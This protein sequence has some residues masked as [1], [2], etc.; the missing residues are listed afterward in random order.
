MMTVIRINRH[1]F[2]AFALIVCVLGFHAQSFAEDIDNESQYRIGVELDWDLTKRLKLSVE[3]QLRIDDD[4]SVD[5]YQLETGLSY[6]TFG[7]LYWGASYRLIVTSSESLQAESS[8]KYGFSA[9]AKEK[10]GRFTPSLR[11]MYSN[12]SDEDSENSE[13]LRYRAKVKYNIRRSSLTPYLAIEAFQDLEESELFKTRYTAGFDLKVDKNRSFDF[14][15]KLDLYSL[16]YKNRH[17][18]SVGYKLSF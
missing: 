12:Y 18:F 3:P 1:I 6:K 2:R 13:F 7:F 5:R 10:Y 15:Y 16:E 17:I 8:S 11:L 4:V 9:T 14:N